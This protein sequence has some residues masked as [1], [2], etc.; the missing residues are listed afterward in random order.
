MA[1]SIPKADELYSLTEVRKMLG[2]PSDDAVLRAVEEG[3]F[4][5]PIR[6]DNRQAEPL[7]M[8]RHLL[9]WIEIR[10]MLRP[11]AETP[12]R[13]TGAR[14]TEADSGELGAN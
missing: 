6:D 14:K 10:P 7:W 12:G 9:L 3:R 5:A 4:P 11:Q 8:G 13:K 1:T 2:F